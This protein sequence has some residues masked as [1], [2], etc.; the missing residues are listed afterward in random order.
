MF[1]IQVI[2]P[3][4]WDEYGASLDGTRKGSPKEKPAFSGGRGSPKKIVS[5]W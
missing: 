3:V 5:C 1:R 4:K 2:V